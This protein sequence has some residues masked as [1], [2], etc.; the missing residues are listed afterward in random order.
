MR[1]QTQQRKEVLGA[2]AMISQYIV[3][4]PER[5]RTYMALAYLPFHLPK[6][7]ELYN[8]SGIPILAQ[9]I[10]PL[11]HTAILQKLAKSHLLA[12]CLLRSYEDLRQRLVE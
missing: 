11:V 8:M 6:S 12:F 10:S 9:Y 7:P 3:T 1:R 4:I 5:L 2:P